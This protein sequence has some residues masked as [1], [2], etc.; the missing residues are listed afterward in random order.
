[1]EEKKVIKIS[2]STFFLI[3]AIV[4]ICFMG[5]FIYKLNS[6]R[7]STS[8]QVSELN[9]KITLLESNQ[10]EPKEEV[11]E[12]STT[13][14]ETPKNNAENAISYN[15]ISGIYEG[16]KKMT[17][18]STVSYYL[19]LFEN[20]TYK[21]TYGTDILLGTV[22]NYIIVDNT[23]KLNKFFDTAS[24]AGM[25]A[26]L[27]K[28]EITINDDTSL[29]DASKVT[30]EDGLPYNI[31]LKKSSNKDLITDYNNTNINNQ[32]KSYTLTNDMN[33]P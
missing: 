8:K 5:Y 21:Y 12:T 4:A 23:I 10:S 16:S 9:R 11:V 1:M 25:V 14:D 15:D 24:S 27:G 17:D 33:Q 13:I 19:Y 18:G 31:T 26:T 28:F 7:M 30:E 32:I 22:G 2:L 29:T 20:G 6:E 3:L